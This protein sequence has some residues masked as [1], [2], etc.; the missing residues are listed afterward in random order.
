MRGFEHANMDNVRVEH[1]PGRLALSFDD[2]RIHTAYLRRGDTLLA[3]VP[4]RQSEPDLC[5]S[6]WKLSIIANRKE[7]VPL[8]TGVESGQIIDAMRRFQSLE[9]FSGLFMAHWPLMNHEF[10]GN[11]CEES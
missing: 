9:G 5:E 2:Q 8:G 6:S 3:N 10:I 4:V 1:V 11:I 7:K